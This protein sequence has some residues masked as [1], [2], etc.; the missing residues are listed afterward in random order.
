MTEIESNNPVFDVNETSFTIP[1][2]SSR[3]LE[4]GYNPVAG[5][6]DTG[7]LAITSN[8]PN[9]PVMYVPLSGRGFAYGPSPLIG[10]IT[11]I[12]ARAPA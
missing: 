12:P 3:T 4:I 10:S 2:N 11:D 9:D 5:Q 1:P 6:V 8:D 7:S